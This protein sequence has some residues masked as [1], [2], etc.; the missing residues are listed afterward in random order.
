MIKAAVFCLCVAHLVSA[1]IFTRHQ[2][3]GWS[4]SR[5]DAAQNTGKRL[6]PPVQYVSDIHATEPLIIY[7]VFE[8][9]WDNNIYT[10][11]Q[12]YTTDNAVLYIFC[13]DWNLIYLI[14]K[15]NK[16]N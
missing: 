3:K 10:K 7:K 6:V 2:N 15:L 16:Y 4:S 12:S 5:A 8:N 9:N 14:N 11:I 13:V 1:G